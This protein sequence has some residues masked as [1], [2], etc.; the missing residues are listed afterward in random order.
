MLEEVSPQA[1]SQVRLIADEYGGPSSLT[2]GRDFRGSGGKKHGE[3]PAACPSGGRVPRS[4]KDLGEDVVSPRPAE[5][6][7]S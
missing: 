2:S 7:L 6:I 3:D 5:W 4:T 1:P